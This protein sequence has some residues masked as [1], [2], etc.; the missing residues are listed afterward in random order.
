MSTFQILTRQRGATE[1]PDI[2][3][4]RR[5]A[6]RGMAVS[7]A[8]PSSPPARLPQV[9]LRLPALQIAGRMLPKFSFELVRASASWIVLALGALLAI[10]LIFGGRVPAPSG[11]DTPTWTPPALAPAAPLAPAWT[12][13]PAAKTAA[14]PPGVENPAAAQPAASAPAATAIADPY[15]APPADNTPL[16]PAAAAATEA[17]YAPPGSNVPAAEPASR[18]EL[19]PADHS[20]PAPE[21]PP[22]V[23]E[24]APQDGTARAIAKDVRVA[25]RPQAARPE[26]PRPAPGQAMPLGIGTGVPQ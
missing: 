8:Q 18:Y 17:Q 1:E 25:S 16:V 9:V 21:L 14:A 15:A 23:A 26:P 5:A 19:P 3:S 13:P 22:P 4:Y 24:P 6:R 20:L 11:I 10:W 7:D 2:V 12:P